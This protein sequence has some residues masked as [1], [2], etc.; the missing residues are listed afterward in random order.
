MI[1]RCEL[2]SLS[3]GVRFLSPC[4]RPVCQSW[5]ISDIRRRHYLYTGLS[6]ATIHDQTT[7]FA[8]ASGQNEDVF[9]VLKANQNPSVCTQLVL[10]PASV[11][12]AIVRGDFKVIPQ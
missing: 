4:M 8:L 7:G 3:H 6:I 11:I 2:L 5:E 1:E 12:P 10:S 9:G